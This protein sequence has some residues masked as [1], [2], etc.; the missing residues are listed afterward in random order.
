MKKNVTKN[1]IRRFGRLVFLNTSILTDYGQ[2]SYAKIDLNIVKAYLTAAKER[3]KPVISAIGHESTAKILTGLTGENI[4][5]NRIQYKQGFNDIC[6]V[7][8]L[9]GRPE[10]GKILTQDEI[11]AIGYEFGVLYLLG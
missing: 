8:K 11:E 1:D 9:K 6:I 2:Y 3:I 7:F 4:P 10:E 5:M